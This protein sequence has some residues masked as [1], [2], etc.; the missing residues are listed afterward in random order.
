ERIKNIIKNLKKSEKKLIPER[1]KKII[2]SKSEREKLPAHY[3]LMPKERK[4]PVKDPAT[5]KYHCGLLRA[6]IFRA[7]QHN[8][9]QVEKKARKLYEKHCKNSKS[10]SDIL[11]ELGY[12]TDE[13][14]IANY[15]YKHSEYIDENT[16]SYILPYLVNPYDLPQ[17]NINLSPLLIYY[18]LNKTSNLLDYE[19]NIKTSG[20]GTV[21]ALLAGLGLMGVL[22]FAGYKY[23]KHHED[24]NNK[25]LQLFGK[26]ASFMD[27][28]V[29]TVF[30]GGDLLKHKFGISE[31]ELFLNLNKELG[32]MKGKETEW[33]GIKAKVAGYSFDSEHLYNILSH[34]KNDNRFEKGMKEKNFKALAQAITD[35]PNASGYLH[36]Y[37]EVDVKDLV[38]HLKNKGENFFNKLE[39]SVLSSDIS[40]EGKK[41]YLS[42]IHHMKNDFLKDDK[43]ISEVLN[44]L[45]PSKRTVVVHEHGDP[46][47]EA[48]KV[49]DTL[50]DLH[51]AFNMVKNE[52][53]RRNI[54]N[55]LGSNIVNM[56]V[57]SFSRNIG[58]DEAKELVRVLKEKGHFNDID[59]E[60]IEK[61]LEKTG[62]SSSNNSNKGDNN[63]STQTQNIQS[64][65]STSS[66]SKTEHSREQ[67][68]QSQNKSEQP[69]EKEEKNK[70][71]N[72]EKLTNEG[73]ISTLSGTLK[74][75]KKSQSKSSKKQNEKIEKTEE[76]DLNKISESEMKEIAKGLD[77]ELRKRKEEETLWNGS[78]THSHYSL[79]TTEGARRALNSIKDHPDFKEA[80]KNKNYK[81]LV[82]LILS[83][84]EASENIEK[85]YKLD[86]P[87]FI[88]L[89][90]NNP[91][92]FFKAK[93]KEIEKISDSQEKEK[94]K[95]KL[96]SIKEFLND[97]KKVN[98][99]L[100]AVQNKEWFLYTQGK[101]E[102]PSF[103]SVWNKI[104]SLYKGYRALEVLE[105]RGEE[106][107]NYFKSH[108][109]AP[110]R[111][112]GLKYIQL[113]K[114]NSLEDMWDLERLYDYLEDAGFIKD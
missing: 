58:Y 48:F 81:Q 64:T 97:N 49:T 68:T 84:D 72:K 25:H 7:A 91:D 30:H 38:H 77:I 104:E 109:S 101:R 37:Y 31:K 93:E 12:I 19:N 46:Y 74:P 17:N 34:I 27:K 102:Q 94:E 18:T 47:K 83:S 110:V 112:H 29:G 65:T 51:E 1:I 70:K 11:I 20:A 59:K 106:I 56:L 79:Y 113:A 10:S 108:E 55:T 66:E 28:L 100:N 39:E 57:N 60:R 63:T 22:G 103:R 54:Q 15:L 85:W 95:E 44:N 36:K 96:K 76:I 87:K 35:T 82:D 8:Y 80:F 73:T 53:V 75:E 61:Y 21:L 71:E 99:V 5:G 13:K 3:F 62:Q 92:Q 78:I 4:F 16:L 40:E 67:S 2:R 52:N 69:P 42:R 114:N 14:Y 45:H 24:Y 98:K 6:A 32:G 9:K 26:E 50:M 33:N 88:N 43:K 105:Q 41:Y 86:I 111:K 23:M 89:V 107:E 90:K